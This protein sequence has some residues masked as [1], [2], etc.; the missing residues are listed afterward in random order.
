MSEAQRGCGYRKIGGLYL[1]CDP[2]F[3][4]SCDGLPM[5]LESCG[6]CGFKPSFT[7]G[8]QR[9]QPE[10]ISQ[11]EDKVHGGSREE[12]CHCP[13]ACPICNP[14]T[15][16]ERG[17]GFGLMF[18][19]R[20]YTASSF[21]KE[22]FNMGVSKR[23]SQIPSWLELGKTWI[24][25]AQ[26]EL[27]NVSLEELKNNGMH[28]KEPEKIQAVFYAFQPQRVE[29]PVWKGSLTNDE[30][31]K[32][33][34]KGITPVFLDPTPENKKRHGE[35]KTM[36]KNLERFLKEEELEEDETNE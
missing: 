5:P 14:L 6:C 33:E 34:K 29:M 30:I 15:T 35:A 23:I 19:G 11:V 22:A 28:M 7:E 25:L 24:L 26:K 2:G 27:P 8:I 32:L 20:E 31:L 3:Q 4:M 16:R 13:G 17:M 18:V 10:Y 36:K 12:Q 1:V 9:L 21:M